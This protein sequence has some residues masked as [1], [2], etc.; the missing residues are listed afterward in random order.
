MPNNITHFAI[1]A[2]DLPRAR[3]FYE[4][5]FGWQ[6]TPWG[7]PDFLQIRTGTKDDPGVLGALQR[8]D[9]PVGDG[10][11]RTFTCTIGVD[12]L[13][14]TLEKIITSGG[15]VTMPPFVI[16]GVGTLAYFEDTEG[17]RVGA[18]EYES[19]AGMDD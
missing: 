11:A 9:D 17:N 13:E 19:R 10:G 7:P 3:R 2:D 18:M 8:R 5:V 16:V 4:D 12:S 1:E 6:F 15:S 14:A